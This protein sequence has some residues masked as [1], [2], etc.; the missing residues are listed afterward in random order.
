MKKKSRNW[1]SKQGQ[2]PAKVRW[3]RSLR[4]LRVPEH[5]GAKGPH[6]E[7]GSLSNYRTAYH[8]AASCIVRPTTVNGV[9]NRNTWLQNLNHAFD[10]P[11]VEAK[12]TG[13][14][15]GAQIH[16]SCDAQ[17]YCKEHA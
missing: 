12:S 11:R 6:E 3:S 2:E 15:H 9:M 8:H 16:R 7:N 13:K 4:A 14:V 5:V 17:M 1:K 10:I